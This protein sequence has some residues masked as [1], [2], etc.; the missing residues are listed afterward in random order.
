[1]LAK[2]TFKDELKDFQTRCRASA[3]RQ[4]LARWIANDWLSEKEW[5]KIKKRAPR[6]APSNLIATV[7]HA[8]RSAAASIN[9]TFG[10]PGIGK[11]ARF[12]APGFKDEWQVFLPALKKQIAQIPVTTGP[13]DV[14][15]MLEAAAR[16]VRDLH[17]FY[18]GFSDQVTFPLSREGSNDDRKRRV[19]WELLAGYFTKKCGGK[20][21]PTVAVLSEVAFPDQRKATDA[22]DVR[23][24]LK[25]RKLATKRNVSKR[26]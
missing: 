4:M 1:M 9:R 3:D 26:R 20:L 23:D 15:D 7:L 21:Q 10:T 22:T 16:D 17:R 25:R 12:A 13:L 11:A 14:A 24:W 5:N 6:L 2:R 8:R 19:F 18:F